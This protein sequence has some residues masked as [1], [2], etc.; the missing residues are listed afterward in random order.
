[1]MI[2]LGVTNWY[3]RRHPLRRTDTPANPGEEEE[4][5]ESNDDEDRRDEE[6]A[7]SD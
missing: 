1:M 3:I 2:T 4:L 6:E 5:G 7:D